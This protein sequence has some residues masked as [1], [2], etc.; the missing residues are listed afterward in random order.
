MPRP[1]GMGPSARMLAALLVVPTALEGACARA[2]AVDAGSC[3]AEGHCQREHVLLQG[4]VQAEVVPLP[5]V[6]AITPEPGQYVAAPV[7]ILSERGSVEDVALALK[8]GF[9]AIAAALPQFTQE[10]P[11]MPGGYS[12]LGGDLLDAVR[13]IVPADLQGTENF[14][15]LTRNWAT[16]VQTLPEVVPCTEEDLGEW[17]RNGTSDVLIRMLTESL[18]RLVPVAT[19]A[20]PD[21]RVGIDIAKYL[22]SIGDAVEGTGEGVDLVREGQAAEGIGAIF[23]GLRDS[24]THLMPPEMANDQNFQ[25]I[26]SHADAPISQIVQ[27]FF[28]VQTG[29]LN[30]NVCWKRTV[31]RDRVRPS[32]CPEGSTLTEQQWC[33]GVGGA[34]LPALCG[35][36]AQRR[37]QWCYWDCAPG[38]E[39]VNNHCRQ[40]C[41]GQYPRNGPL[42]CGNSPGSV[43]FALFQMAAQTVRTAL[44]FNG[45]LSEV[46]DLGLIGAE[47][48][49]GT[50]SRFVEVSQ[51]FRHPVCEERLPGM[52]H[53][54][55]R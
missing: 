20:F 36:S 54:S 10:F 31:R 24:T 44:T 5:L 45:L 29:I 28:S 21:L 3:A 49:T 39:E 27:H 34:A 41:G 40:Q 30:S 11:D 37:G 46:V 16:T 33:L 7:H 55:M 22:V 35:E 9:A 42:M 51:P 53:D 48:L 8:R 26:A 32:V 19:M 43:G 52:D 1:A 15:S 18:R 23:R 47:A 12:R 4:K 13:A 25:I 14:Q 50:M 2:A 6:P 38:Y 17:R